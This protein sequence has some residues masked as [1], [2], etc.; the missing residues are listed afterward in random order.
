MK[1]R[2]EIDGLRALAVIPVILFHAGFKAFSGGFVG[3]DIFFVISGYLITTI[4]LNEKSSGNFTLIGFYE[5]RFRRILPALFMVIFVCCPF[6]WLWFTPEE[7]ARFS[8]SVVAVVVFGSNVLFW[9]TSGYFDA[10]AELKPLLHTWSLGV[11]E[12][13]YFILPLII[14]FTLQKGKNILF[15]TLTLIFIGSFSL[16]VW[17]SEVYP[18]ATFF[19]LPTRMWELLIGALIACYLLSNDREILSKSIRQLLS[20]L[21]LILILVAFLTFDNKTPIP[22]IY[23]LMPTL[24]AALIIL[25]SDTTTVVGRILSS[26]PFVSIGLIS[27]S[28]YLWHQPLLAFARHQHI[29]EP[30]QYYLGFFALISILL[31]YLSWRY[32]EKPFRDIKN[33]KQKTIFIIWMVGSF[34]FLC[35]G[36][37]GHFTQGNFFKNLD[38]IEISIINA[39]GDNENNI[40]CWKKI[41]ATSDLSNSCLLGS[42]GLVKTFV[43]LGDSHAATLNN[44]LNLASLKI[45]QGGYDF[46]YQ[47]CPP[48]IV[49]E[50]IEQDFNAKI[51][52]SLRED[53]YNRVIEKKLPKTIIIYARWTLLVEGKRFNNEEGGRESGDDFQWG[54]PNE[55]NSN[56]KYSISKGISDSV[57]LILDS[58][59]KVI[60]IYPTPEMGWSVPNRLVGIY[61]KNNTLTVSD[62]STSYDVFQ[63]RNKNAYLALDSIGLHPNLVRI[64]PEELLCNLVISGRCLAHKDGIPYYIDD[65]HLS[66]SGASLIVDQITKIL[67]KN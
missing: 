17:G 61:R 51:C 39:K 38:P 24:G 25:F 36:L 22:G 29:S 20:I 49:G 23:A 44:Q 67:E 37:V 43:V 52:T 41:E 58:G 32:I 48:M 53:F 28:T 54:M 57:K 35:L 1:Y 8:Q 9:L 55:E 50:P 2:S 26:K 13:F 64:K 60:L 18:L 14:I 47:S 40:K 31:G 42:E 62:A 16:A 59:Y 15:A 46:T 10:T 65:D 11:E 63:R 30:S 4:I 27:Y 19:L 66:N 34:I 6:A 5:R 45:Q 56:S 12:Q 7:M 33:Y 3:V 21:G